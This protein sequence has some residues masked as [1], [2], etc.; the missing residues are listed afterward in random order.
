MDPRDVPKV[1]AIDKEIAKITQQNEVAK[2]VYDLLK[3]KQQIEEGK[4]CS[5]RAICQLLM[6]IILSCA[7]QPLRSKRKGLVYCYSL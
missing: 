2:K 7:G 4:Y 1:T 5:L 6:Y 3:R